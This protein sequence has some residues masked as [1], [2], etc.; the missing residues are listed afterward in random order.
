MGELA[1]L[2]SGRVVG[3]GGVKV[4]EVSHDSRLVAP[5]TMYVALVGSNVD[6]HD[7]VAEAVS[8]GAT[9]IC[10]ERETA[11]GVPELLVGDTRQILGQLSAAVYDY[12]SHA[13]DVVGV[14]GTNGKTTVTHYIDSVGRRAGRLTG[15][16]G[17]I[18][19]RIAGEEVPS[20]MTTP[21]ASEFQRLLADMREAGVS[22]VA[23][24]VSS[25]AL[26]FGR[27][28]ATRFSVAAFTNLSQDHL[29]FHG[30]MTRYREAKERL[31]REYDVT[32]AVI[33]IDDPVGAEIAAG[34]PGDL[35]TVGSVGD[36]RFSDPMVVAG[37]SRFDL[38]TPAGAASIHAPVMGDFNVSNMAVAAAS[39]L[40]VGIDFDVVVDGLAHMEGVPGRFEIVSGDDPIVVIVDYAHTPEGVSRAVA[41]ARGLT[42]GRVI[43]LI[44]AGG[45]RDRE[46]RPAM[47]AAISRADLA[48]V[49]SDNPRSEEPGDIVEAVSSG[50]DRG[51]PHMIEVD[52]RHAIDMAVAA[53]EEG[54]VVLILGRGH[55]PFQ[56]VGGEKIPFDDREIAAQALI[57]KRRSVGNGPESGSIVP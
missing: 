14:T 34:Y 29:D 26:E 38:A 4:Q 41:A 49:T 32:T 40:A 56:Q 43:G 9:T 25:H 57:A 54:D 47:G 37:G 20:S 55:E 1:Q 22:L 23:A 3:D 17:T 21:E 8:N 31:F 27:V 10:A 45:D 6:G 24:E 50:L 36:V 16:V 48:I 19:T 15:L 5:G 30:D 35:I 2:V 42:D 53:A 44:G 39:C 52:R 12:P 33:N 11:S 18:R 13:M 28:K 51:R 7:F 46:K